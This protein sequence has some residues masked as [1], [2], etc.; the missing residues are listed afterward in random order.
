VETELLHETVG[1]E[2]IARLSSEIPLGLGTVED[3]GRACVYLASDLCTQ[4]TGNINAG[5]SPA[6]PLR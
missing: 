3:I 2:R 4:M 5:S 1:D 6:A